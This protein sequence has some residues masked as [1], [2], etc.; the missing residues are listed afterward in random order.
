MEKSPLGLSRFDLALA[1][2]AVA[3]I[4]YVLSLGAAV[5]L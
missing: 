1:M 4:L 3:V 2:L 5:Q